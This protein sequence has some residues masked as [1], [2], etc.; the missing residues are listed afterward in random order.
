MRWMFLGFGLT[1]AALCV[2]NIWL[3]A[4]HRATEISLNLAAA[5]VTGLIAC[6]YLA[7]FLEALWTS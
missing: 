2:V 1:L 3:L 7:L 6:V 5:V 4:T